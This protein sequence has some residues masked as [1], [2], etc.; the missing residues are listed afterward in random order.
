MSHM[1]LSPE[2]FLRAEPSS[3][4]VTLNP[5]PPKKEGLTYSGGP[6]EAYVSTHHSPGGLRSRER[7]VKREER[8][9]M[10]TGLQPRPRVR[11]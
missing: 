6:P 4:G 1:V 5:T 2:R 9:L 7:I 10:F 3:L 11:E 8:I